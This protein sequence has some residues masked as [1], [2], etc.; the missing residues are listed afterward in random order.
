MD[1]EIKGRDQAYRIHL[2]RGSLLSLGHYMDLNRRVLILTDEGIPDSYVNQVI[3]QC[4]TPCPVRVPSGERSKSLKTYESILQVMVDKGFTRRDCLLA[5]GGGVVGDLGGFLAATYMRGIDFYTLPTSLLAQID[6]S[7]GGKT[8]L[9]FGG[10]KNM[11]GAFHHPRSVVVDPDTLASLPDRQF[12]NGMGE[13][14]KTAV[15]LD[16]NLYRILCS[17]QAEDRMEE[18]I[19]ACLRSKARIIQE[20]FTDR[21]IRQVLNFGHTVGHAIEA[22]SNLLHGESVAIGMTY[23]TSPKVLTSLL[24]LLKAYGLPTKTDIS[25]DTLFRAILHDKKVDGGEV[26]AIAVEEVGQ[27]LI[28][29][30]SLERME[31]LLREKEEENRT[32]E[33]SHV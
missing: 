27:P 33:A 26:R 6:S 20:D 24:P 31:D 23:F 3:R 15:I 9:N 1:L 2:G 11:V 5:L 7:I 32:K 17:H 25:A 12:R 28:R 4:Q 10:L 8:A 30:I 13:V 16:P 21:G 22:S 29:R 18:V 19:M 14:I